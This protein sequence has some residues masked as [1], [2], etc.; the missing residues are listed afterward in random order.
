VTWSL[1]EVDVGAQV[2]FILIFPDL[3]R[4]CFPLITTS[5]TLLLRSSYIWCTLAGLKTGPY[6]RIGSRNYSLRTPGVLVTFPSWLG[7]SL[8]LRLSNLV[9]EGS[10]LWVVQLLSAG[11]RIFVGFS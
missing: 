10:E 5:Y 8:T 4:R 1:A 7:P 6:K 2:S 9:F 11:L 3:F